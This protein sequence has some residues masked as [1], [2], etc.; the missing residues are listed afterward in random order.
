MAVVVD[1]DEHAELVMAADAVRAAD[2]AFFL[3]HTSGLLYVAVT[4]EHVEALKLPLMVEGSGHALTVSVDARH[5]ATTGISAHDRALTVA[6]LVDTGTRP[7]D[8]AR[9]G[10]MFPVR[11]SA[12]GVLGYA[13]GPEA[14]VDLARAAGR[15]PAGMMSALVSSNKAG[16]ADASEIAAFVE[17]YELPARLGRPARTAPPQTEKIVPAG[18]TQARIPTG[19]ATFSASSYVSLVDGERHFALVL[20]AVGDG[21]DV[22]VRFHPE[23][24]AGDVFGSRRCSC[25]AQLRTALELIAS[26]GRGVLVYLRGDAGHGLNVAHRLR[27]TVAPGTGQGSGSI[28]PP[29]PTPGYGIGAQ[30]LLDL[31]V[32][33]VRPIT[34]DARRVR[35]DRELRTPR[36]GTPDH[37]VG[38][39]SRPAAALRPGE[40]RWRRCSTSSTSSC[41][42]IR[43]AGRGSGERRC[44]PT[45]GARSLQLGDGLVAETPVRED[46]RG[47]RARGFRR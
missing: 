1:E 9:P 29:S 37:A 31:G 41:N 36:D 13:G 11:C 2:I 20:G 42:G 15:A 28:R 7:G 12:G 19:G 16:M 5:G 17:R 26:E 44:R 40:R 24:V 22:V 10:H 47:R 39:I 8:L 18:A 34:T 21:G 45:D 35:R 43:P 6:A 38:G 27:P 4:P 14:A 32:S 33:T 25:G 46:G 3:R 30:I 23:C